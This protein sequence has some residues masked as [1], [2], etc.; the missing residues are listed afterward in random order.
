VH[1]TP[2]FQ[3]IKPDLTASVRAAPLHAPTHTS[4]ATSKLGQ[5]VGPY[6]ERY[7]HDDPLTRYARM[8]APF[9][10]RP[11][12]HLVTRN[13]MCT[14]SGIVFFETYVGAVVCSPSRSFAQGRFHGHT[15]FFP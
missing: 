4:F 12:P 8:G 6:W 7:W 3:R 11:L 5:V 2:G 10:H 13:T 9:F 1:L 14:H 15:S